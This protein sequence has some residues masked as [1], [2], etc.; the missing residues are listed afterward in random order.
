MRT[1]FFLML[2]IVFAGGTGSAQTNLSLT[3]EQAIQLALDNSKVLHA[4]LMRLNYADAKSAE[5]NASRLPVLKFTGAYTRLSDVPPFAVSLPSTLPPP[6]GGSSFTLAP[7]I[8]NNY[9]LRASLEQPLFTGFRLSAAAHAADYAARASEHDYAK[10]KTDL[11]YNVRAAYWSLFK[12]LEFK[13]VVDENVEQVKAHLNDVQNLVNQGM[14]TKNDLL[15]VQVQLSDAQLRQI[16]MNNNVQL[17]MI[18]LNNV[19]GIPLHTRISIESDIRRSTPSEFGELNSLISKAIENRPEMK[20]MDFRVKA[21]DAGVTAAKGEWFP[22][23]YLAANYNYNKPN[24]RIQ[25]MQDLFKD[26]WDVTLAVS[27]DIWNWGK[28]LHQTDQAS[29]QYEEAKD[30]FAQLRDGITLEITQNYLNLNQAKER[31]L[32]AEKGVTHAEENYR[33]TNKRFKE[34]LA[35]NSDLLDAEV[36]LL[37]AKTNSTQALVDVELAGARLQKAIGK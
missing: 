37:Q 32:V 2:L 20:A 6:F 5:M 22:Q 14:A 13:K 24:Q 16:E 15:K 3:V 23:I 4:S 12:A 7:T 35:Q 31:T 11:A 25:P 36:A 34:G 9:T 33:V 28:T 1:R 26:T 19:M 27:L 30:A 17:A 21:A 18:G 29:A 8:Q 10:D